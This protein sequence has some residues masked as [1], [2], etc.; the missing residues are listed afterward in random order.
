MAKKKQA[1]PAGPAAKMAVTKLP[2][3][4]VAWFVL[5]TFNEDG[6]GFVP[7]MVRSGEQGYYRNT[8]GMGGTHDL[9]KP[10]CYRWGDTVEQAR[11]TA[12]AVNLRMG[13]TEEMADLMVLE[14][15]RASMRG[16]R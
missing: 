12:A 16:G 11:A 7:G 5:V 9:S 13:V 8:N 14:S 2:T 3:G 6:M 10:L 1:A 4:A 15:M